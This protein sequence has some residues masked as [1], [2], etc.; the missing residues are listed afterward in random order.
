M[1]VKII[2]QT[3]L[4]LFW[5]R[6]NWMPAQILWME[7]NRVENIFVFTSHIEIYCLP[8]IFSMLLQNL[9]FKLLVI[10]QNLVNICVVLKKII[11]AT[12][13]VLIRT[14]NYNEWNVNF[15]QNWHW[16]SNTVILAGLL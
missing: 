15:L 7:E 2:L 11:T 6:P 5:I 16:A 10:N 1:V 8:I 14:E 9:K 4:I 3:N 13:V 12:E